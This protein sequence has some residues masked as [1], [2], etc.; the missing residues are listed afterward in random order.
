MGGFDLKTITR[1]RFLKASASAMA[2]PCIIPSS[3]L[4]AQAP[5]N[6][7][8]LGVI[9]LGGRGRL[10]TRTFVNLPGCDVC[11][12]CDPFLS[13]CEKESKFVNEQTGKNN[14]T[15]HQDFRE[16]LE[17]PDIDAVVIASP[18]NWHALQSIMAVAKG[19]DVFCEKAISRTVEEGAA[20]VSAVRRRGRVLQVG[21]QQRSSRLFRHVCELVRNGYVGKLREVRVGV[22][23]GM[24]L[25]NKPPMDPPADLNYD[26]WLGPAPQTPYNEL[27]CQFNWYFMSD[28]CAGWIESW[29]VHHCDTALWG[30]PELGVGM[31]T[32]EGTAEFPNDGMA[33]TSISWNTRLT[34]AS[35]LVLSFADNE[36]P[37]H[38]QGC[39]FI[40]DDGWIHVN[41]SGIWA[42]PE[43]LPSIR[44][45]SRETRLYKSDHHQS[46]FLESIRT[47]RAPAAPIEAGHRATTVTLIADIATRLGRKLTWDWAKQRFIND[48]GANQMLSRPM[49]APWRL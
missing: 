8:A 7:I 22:P 11:A 35:G 14:C 15:A 28:Y 18:E 46:N 4:G 16:I 10:H 30:A 36:V 13:I 5:S 48:D 21:T 23:R 24:A 12:V 42:E 39:R 2:M 44:L 33:D 37:G 19:K 34:T 17:R 38:G 25:P 1:R 43:S 40:G 6:R 47:R 9:G 45:T 26:L 29:G 3:V 31:V 20:M 41:R 49:R 27:K 32:I